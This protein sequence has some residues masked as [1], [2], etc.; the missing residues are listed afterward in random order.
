MRWSLIQSQGTAKIVHFACISIIG[1]SFKRSPYPS[2]N[3]RVVTNW[4]RSSMTV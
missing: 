4:S 3:S 2:S 1:W